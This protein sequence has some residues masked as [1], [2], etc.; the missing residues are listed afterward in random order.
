MNVA[1]SSKTEMKNYFKQSNEK[2]E[3][4]EKRKTVKLL[5]KHSSFEDNT[6]LGSIKHSIKLLLTS[7]GARITKSVADIH[8]GIY[9]FFFKKKKTLCWHTHSTVLGTHLQLANTIILT[10]PHTYKK[11]KKKM[12]AYTDS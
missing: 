4:I 9:I 1:K 5:I 11:K 2:E 10:F 7:F 3:K 8:A 12:N 6:F